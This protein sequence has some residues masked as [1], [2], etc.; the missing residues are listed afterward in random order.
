[1]KGLII[2][3][4]SKELRYV[5]L[6]ANKVP[7]PGIDY[8][9]KVL[10]EIEMC[11]KLYNDKCRDKEYSIIFSNSDEVDFEIKNKN[12]CHLLGID[13]KNIKGSYFDDYR[14]EAFDGQSDMS[15]FELIELIIDNMDAVALLDNDKNNKA[16]AINY[17]KA[18]IKCAIFNKLCNFDKINFGAINFNGDKTGFDYNKQKILFIPSNEAIVPYFMMIIREDAADY[19]GKYIAASLIAPEN[20]LYYFKN[21][22]VIIP[23]QILVSD[24]SNLSKVVAAP[25]DKIRLLT[26]YSDI[27]NKYRIQNN[28]NI[29]GDYLSILNELSNSKVYSKTK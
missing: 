25:E 16:K 6:W 10:K 4:T 12:L 20:P 22:E 23:T 18:S 29:Y 24:N 14:R 3:I 27:I 5:N 8:S 19:D 1:M 13:Y 21:Q 9:I 11:Y 28:I 15:S 17:Y 26:M 2:M 7:M